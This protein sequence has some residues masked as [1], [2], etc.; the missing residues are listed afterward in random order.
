MD[1]GS[2]G[3]HAIIA[4][5]VEAGISRVP[6][7]A[8]R[9]LLGSVTGQIRRG[10]ALAQIVKLMTTTAAVGISDERPPG[11]NFFCQG[12][13]RRI[14]FFDTGLG[15]QR[16]DDGINLVGGPSIG[17]RKTIVN[18]AGH[19][20]ALHRGIAV[21]A[22]SIDPFG[23]EKTGDRFLGSVGPKIGSGRGGCGDDL[24]IEF[25][26]PTRLAIGRVCMAARTMSGE[27][28]GALQLGII[29]QQFRCTSTGDAAWCANQFDRPC[30]IQFGHLHSLF[31]FGV[32]LVLHDSQRG[33]G[34]HP[35]AQ[36]HEQA[37]IEAMSELPTTKDRH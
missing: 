17:V 16:G 32:V 6:Q 7:K 23:V 29:T 10:P 21:V 20:P 12:L 4:F 30:T 3:W 11:G 34:H 15:D 25:P 18:K 37:D 9:P 1:V 13:V 24:R 33:Q 28:N 26:F 22:W 5:A 2:V 19:I 36:R 8:D 14:D 27:Q 35:D 31:E